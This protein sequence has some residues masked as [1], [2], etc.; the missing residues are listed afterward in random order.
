MADWVSLLIS[1]ACAAGGAYAAVRKE[2][3]ELLA[4]MSLAEKAID[5]AHERID[6]FQRHERSHNG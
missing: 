5:R 2:I 6:N 1:A 3:G 4:R